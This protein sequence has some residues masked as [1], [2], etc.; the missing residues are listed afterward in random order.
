LI[1]KEFF[2]FLAEEWSQLWTCFPFLATPI[3]DFF[4]QAVPT[5]FQDEQIQRV[6]SLALANEAE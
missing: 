4:F 2:R 6:N 1:F 5:G 3:R